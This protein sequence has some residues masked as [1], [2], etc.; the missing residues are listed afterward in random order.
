MYI[1]IYNPSIPSSASSCS[2]LPSCSE[3]FIRDTKCLLYNLKK[4]RFLILV[5]SQSGVQ[6]AAP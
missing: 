3:P 4:S 6:T 5:H 1:Y 2:S